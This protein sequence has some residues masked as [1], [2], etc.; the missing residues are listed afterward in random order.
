MADEDISF[1]VLDEITDHPV[2]TIRIEA[3]NRVIF[4]MAD[5]AEVDDGRTLILR[6]L[7]IH[8]EDGSHSTGRGLL[9]RIAHRVIEVMDYDAI[10]VEGSTRTTGAAPGHQPRVLRFTRRRRD[11]PQG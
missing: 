3:G 10:I 6:G 1:R 9:R 8:S 2:V 11:P 5:V 4:V 7:H